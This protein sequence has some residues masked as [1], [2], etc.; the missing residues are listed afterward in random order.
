[1]PFA[2]STPGGLSMTGVQTLLTYAGDAFGRLRVS[3][4]VVEADCKFTSDLIPL[5]FGAAITR[6]L[7]CAWN[8]DGTPQIIAIVLHSITGTSAA[9]CAFAWEVIR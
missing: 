7:P 3:E 9:L 2:F 5:R 4:S 6:A 1:M 8:L